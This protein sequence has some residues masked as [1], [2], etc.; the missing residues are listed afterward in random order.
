MLLYVNVDSHFI[1]TT[2]VIM[3]LV[4]IVSY[5]VA[6]YMVMLSHEIYICCTLTIQKA[7]NGS[8]V[9]LFTVLALKGC[10]AR[11]LEAIP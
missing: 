1:H 11:N 5:T 10:Q 9:I 6:S 7:A 3:H 2:N 4:F 8:E